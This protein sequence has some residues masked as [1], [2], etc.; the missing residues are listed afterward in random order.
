M[1]IN[2]NLSTAPY[3]DDYDLTNQYYKILFKPGYAVQAREL[4]QLQTTLQNQIEQFG[5]NVYK[6]GS[7]IKGCNFTQIGG[8]SYVKVQ[9]TDTSNVQFD[10]TKYASRRDSEIIGGVTTAID[11]VYEV[12]GAT[13][14]LKAIIFAG[15]LGLSSRPPNLNTLFISY[16]GEGEDPGDSSRVTAFLEENLIIV[17]K[18][19]KLD[20]L[21]FGE[22]NPI[23]TTTVATVA[24][25]NQTPRV[26]PAFG[27]RAEAGVVFQKGHFLFADAQ[28]LIVSKYT[29]QP[30]QLSVGYQVQ[31]TLVNAFED[32]TLYD[33]ANGSNNF[34]APG[35]DRLRLIP[36]LTVK[37]TAAADADADFF[38]LI[39]YKNGNAVSI[40]DVTQFNTITDE[41]AR[42][43]YEE[44]GNYVVSNFSVNSARQGNSLVANIGPGVAY[45]KGY[46]VENLAENA[47][48]IIPVSSSET[49]ENQFT[50]LNYGNYVS[51]SSY[52]GHI[53]LDF[54]AVDLKDN[55]SVKIGEAFVYNMTPDKVHLM[56]VRM[57][58]GN[59]FRNV[60]I[61]DVATGYIEVANTAASEPVDSIATMEESDKQAL[62]FDT[63]MF[64]LKGTTTNILP[65]RRSVDTTVSVS[66]TI[67]INVSN[68]SDENFNVDHSETL[69]ID[70]TGQKLT[71]TSTQVNLA[72]GQ[73]Q[74]NI[75]PADGAAGNA[76]HVYYNINTIGA[77]AQPHEKI[78]AEP[79]IYITHVFD[80]QDNRWSLGFPDVYEIT[81]VMD[82]TVSPP[83]DYKDSFRLFKN[84]KDHYLDISYME[85]IKGRPIPP[86]GRL[87]I[88]LKVFKVDGSSG[89][90]YF[91]IESYPTAV[92][93]NDITDTNNSLND[94]PV[95]VSSKGKK[96]NLRESID[97]RSQVDKDTLADYTATT[98]GAAPNISAQVGANAPT[99]TTFP[100]IIP[101][102]N[103]YSS[104]DMT[105][106]FTRVD[107]VTVDAYGRFGIVQGKEEQFARPPLLGP[108][109]LVLAEI[110]VPGVPALTKAE[111]AI[112]GKPNYGIRI[113]RKT[114]EGFKMKDIKNIQTKLD[115]LNYYISLS[116][117]ESDTR[118][119]S[120]LDENGLNRFKNGF[121]VESFRDL[122]FADIGDPNYSASLK[123]NEEV[124]MPSVRQ[125]P[126]DLKYSSSVNASIFPATVNPDVVTLSRNANVEI[127]SQPYA[128]SFRN[129]VSNFYNYKGQGALSPEY[130]VAY[131]MTANP[132]PL[133]IDLV[134]VFDDFV[135]N[136]QTFIPLTDV[137]TESGW[138]GLNPFGRRGGTLNFNETVSTLSV[139]ESGKFVGDFITNFEFNPFIAEREI[140]I[141][142]AGL[143]P[144]TPHWFYFDKQ[145]ISAH[146]APGTTADVAGDILKSGNYGI[147]ADG[148][149]TDANG[150]LY[151]VFKVPAET[152]F[153]G[154]RVLQVADVDQYASIESAATSKGT[155]TYRAYNFSIEK[156]EL[157]TREPQINLDQVVV[158]RSV[159]FPRRGDPL[160]QTFFIR[161]GMAEGGDTL[162]LSELSLYFK[163]KSDINGV[164]IYL[165]EIDNGY[166]SGNI[167]P[168]SKVHLKPTEVNI[169]DTASVVTT[170][171]FPAPVR[172]KTEQEYAF[173]IQPDANDPNYLVY[174]SKVGEVDITA[175]AATEGQAIVQDWGDGVLFTSTN[176][177]AWQSYQDEDVKFVLR[178][179]DFNANAG[180]VTLTNNDHEFFTIN[181]ISGRFKRDEHVYQI[182]SLG[183]GTSNVVSMDINTSTVNGVGLDSTYATGDMIII[184][185]SGTK[186]VFKVV[187][188]T[189]STVMT[190]NKPTSF[191]V[192]S[193]S[194]QPI[195]TGRV[196]HFDRSEP[197]NL[198]VEQST[199][200]SGRLF[201]QGEFL[202]GLETAAQANTASI[203]NIEV[204]YIQPFIN[205]TNDA[206][207]R[208]GLT[209]E[210]VPP[211]DTST[212]YTKPLMFNTNG[213]FTKNGAVIFSKSNDIGNSK[214]FEIKIDMSNGA[215][216][217]ASPLIDVELAKLFAYT[218][219]QTNDT[220]TTSKYISKRVE[221][222]ESFDAEDFN[223]IVTAYRPTNTDIKCYIK[224]QNVYDSA[225]FENIPWIEL[226][227]FEGTD[228]YSS[229][230]NTNDYR[231]LRY[232]VPTANKDAQGVLTYTSDAGDFTGYRRFAVRIDL[233]STNSYN[234]PTIKDY[235]GIA[236][237]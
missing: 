208:T 158:P 102:R 14:G 193:G 110:I 196:S 84:H 82:N 181:D 83:V 226:E 126:L 33:N 25:T 62:I 232:R 210:F 144:N 91:T 202:Y 162:L 42:R 230:I 221:L 43:T 92:N 111:A 222:A 219:K 65:V 130:D 113:N 64:S 164:S 79:Y 93:P 138:N 183:A 199:A 50:S 189:S 61:L 132:E 96:Y 51:V 177:R 207:T 94:I 31:E 89:S 121:I 191:A 166:P 206:I 1:P 235:R 123:F 41:M 150:I 156:T 106:Y 114:A 134:T 135:E 176:N 216:S 68:L 131:D 128:T 212:S 186:D 228:T 172:L 175:G 112:K 109:Q 205:R 147:S 86:S 194:G 48:D 237:T 142:M 19:F 127:I 87:D 36:T 179:H 218:Y 108:D 151:A 44:S 23:Q 95:Y 45:V 28:T 30:D 169:S 75:D 39:R 59:N 85:Y 192:S 115:N 234:A 137:V 7:I 185:D 16:T 145:D 24:A 34:N 40:R 12:T 70:N 129:V 78:I 81:E 101:A 125:F 197:E 182:T 120:I 118:D 71:V 220:A 67:L 154:D 159:T 119:L 37:T 56:G 124:L 26:G 236:L 198:Y 136:L 90:N 223:L 203:D 233:L 173:I 35:A 21:G 80:T 139:Q 171:Q 17:E 55:G 148:I 20:P 47:F 27:I 60:E 98:V 4:T 69:V 13:S 38:S 73:L 15:A 104:M 153:V 174:T 97:F 54:T 2:T 201:T 170:V 188:V 152:F 9:D 143:R 76:C 195:V 29:N 22:T 77:N 200:R 168:F 149:T 133:E 141:W 157:S 214:K 146:V 103:A 46:R 140:K 211:A 57:T 122:K 52:Q 66:D 58:P 215:T 63:G 32:E 18:K 155:L 8:L 160:A 187:D 204:G 100:P 190:V 167:I 184:E 5:D 229:N 49:V 105:Y 74:I 53:P 107:A 180:V 6:E 117:L 161:K 10:P 163:R 217:S 72:G 231:E 225:N 224:P 3:F 99:F 11:Y 116:Q 213:Q 227:I 165:S 88:K 178:R 209:G